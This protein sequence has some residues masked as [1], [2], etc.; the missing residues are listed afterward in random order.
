MTIFD[1]GPTQRIARLLARVPDYSAHQHRFWLDWG[2]VFYRGRLNNRQVR[3]LCVASD[4]GPTE[5]I[6]CRSLVGDAGQR[7]Q[8]FLTKLGLTHSYLCLNAFVYSLHP[9]HFFAA[10]AVLEESEQRVWRNQLFDLLT[11]PELQA[12]VAFGALAQRAVALWD[13]CPAVPVVNVRHPSSRDEPELLATWREAITALRAVVTPDSGSNTA[14]ANYGDSF[15]EADY[16]AI[17]KHDLP[18]AL[19]EWF[20]DDAWGRRAKPPHHNCVSR[21]APDDEHT[22]LWIAPVIADA[23]PPGA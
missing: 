7:V 8:G 4:P 19:P 17:P 22:L 12:I 14:R 11:G 23:P 13:G 18:F 20:G 15:T 2:P 10:F 1:K 21:P 16:A 5:R 3:L 6:A 9:S